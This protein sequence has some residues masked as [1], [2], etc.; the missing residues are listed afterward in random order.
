MKIQSSLTG[1]DG[2]SRRDST[3]GTSRR[4]VTM[5][6]GLVLIVVLMREAGD[7]NVYRRLFTRLGVPITNSEGK[8]VITIPI[9]LEPDPQTQEGA[10]LLAGCLEGL[11]AEQRD[12]LTRLLSRHRRGAAGEPS[13]ASDEAIRAVRFACQQQ[14]LAPADALAQALQAISAGEAPAEDS[15]AYLRMLQSELDR[16]YFEQI[17]DG[18]VWNA[19][20]FLA[21]YRS[22]E[23]VSGD[24]ALSEKPVYVGTVPL[25]E[26]ASFYRGRHVRVSGQAVQSTRYE[27]QDNDFGIESY[28]MVW[29]KPIDGSERPVVLYAPQVSDAIAA[30]PEDGVA[31]DGPE[32]EIDA[33]FLKRY[34]YRSVGGFDQAPLLVGRILEPKVVV[35]STPATAGSPSGNL[36]LA[37]GGAL[38]FGVA[39]A[40]LVLWNTNRTN[41]YQRQLRQRGMKTNPDFLANVD[42]DK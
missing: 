36:F 23:R 38:I 14:E 15:V 8:E 42:G 26:Q 25:I 22:L 19:K 11:T 41:Q 2:Q 34:L 1:R 30:L 21:F 31:A 40:V 27:A 24:V 16:T 37:I 7:P 13:D 6:L 10:N 17:E 35:T 20:D 12:Q 28:W 3:S 4:L 29:L 33:V 39:I 5:V 32:L 9:E 18:T